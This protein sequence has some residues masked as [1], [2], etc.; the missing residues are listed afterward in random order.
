MRYLL[1]ALASVALIQADG[2]PSKPIDS[3]RP[4]QPIG[5][6]VPVTNHNLLDLAVDTVTG[7]MCRTWNWQY[8]PDENGLAGLPLCNDLYHLYPTVQTASAAP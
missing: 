4:T 3:A 5:R 6:F 8:K 1:T 7:Q 2:C